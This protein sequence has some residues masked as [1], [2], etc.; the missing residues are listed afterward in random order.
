MSRTNMKM[1]LIKKLS[2]HDAVV[3]HDHGHVATCVSRLRVECWWLSHKRVH[4]SSPRHFTGKATFSRGRVQGGRDRVIPRN[5]ANLDC[6]F[7][8]MHD[9]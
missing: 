3:T 8:K 7:Y 1:H 6:T 9:L 4:S 5:I 2:I